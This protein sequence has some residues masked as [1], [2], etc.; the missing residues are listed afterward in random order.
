MKK[1]KYCETFKPGYYSHILR[2][3]RNPTEIIDERVYYLTGSTKGN[4]WINLNSHSPMWM[5][6]M[7][8]CIRK[9][10]FELPNSEIEYHGSQNPTTFKLDLK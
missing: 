1:K 3:S 8:N 9:V 4:K 10:D 5:S 7:W 2:S 6:L